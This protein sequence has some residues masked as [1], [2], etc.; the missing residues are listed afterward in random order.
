[1]K[2]IQNKEI[3]AEMRS[4]STVSI[5][6][7]QISTDFI[8]KIM[9][10]KIHVFQTKDLTNRGQVGL[11]PFTQKVHPPDGMVEKFVQY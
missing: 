3:N 11:A 2:N 9:C 4:Y 1:M 6:F 5:K 10:D 8:T 7:S